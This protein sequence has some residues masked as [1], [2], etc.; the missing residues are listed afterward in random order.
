MKQIDK[1]KQRAEQAAGNSPMEL[2]SLSQAVCATDIPRL[3]AALAEAV[4]GFSI[5]EK[6]YRYP[7]EI[8]KASLDEISRLLEGKK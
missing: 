3:C 2:K 4:A 1:I 7:E 5:I 8:A 6:G